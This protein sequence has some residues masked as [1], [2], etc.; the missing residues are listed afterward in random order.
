MYIAKTN[1]TGEVVGVRGKEVKT[2]NKELIE[3]LIRA[4]YIEKLEEDK[5]KSNTPAKTGGKK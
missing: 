1:F 2:T 5:P 4:G 3:E